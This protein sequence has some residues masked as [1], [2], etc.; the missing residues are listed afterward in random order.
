MHELMADRTRINA[1]TVSRRRRQTILPPPTCV[2]IFCVASST[3]DAIVQS[4]VQR[5][6]R[7]EVPQNSRPCSVC[8]TSMKQ[9]RV[10]RPIRPPSPRGGAFARRED[11]E[12]L[13]GAATK[14]PW[15]AHTRTCDGIAM[16]RSPSR[17]RIS[18]PQAR[19]FRRACAPSAACRSRCP[20]PACRRQTICGTFGAPASDTLES[21]ERMMSTGAR[22]CA[23]RVY[24]AARSSKGAREDAGR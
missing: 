13:R 12:S 9:Q 3:N 5:K 2:R 22:G 8:T 10:E 11:G 18:P 7:S 17:V 16:R 15:L 21:P 24:P 1:A 23:R 14:S 20:A 19:L 6:H 4:P